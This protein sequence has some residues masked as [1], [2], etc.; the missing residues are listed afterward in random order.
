MSV[1]AALAALGAR[2]VYV[3]V[4]SRGDLAG[5]SGDVKAEL[6]LEKEREREG[7]TKI[8]YRTSK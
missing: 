4:K 8:Q 6:E 7:G 1:I 3:N 5:T 2:S